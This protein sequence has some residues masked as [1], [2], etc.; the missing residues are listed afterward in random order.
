MPP[1]QWLILV[2][3]DGTLTARDADL[4]IA[5]AAVGPAARALYAPLVEAYEGLR[6]GLVEFFGGL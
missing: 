2:D 4:V 6:I 5:D 3:F 1:E